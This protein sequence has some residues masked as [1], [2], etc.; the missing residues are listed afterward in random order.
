VGRF[1][2]AL[3]KL[4]EAESMLRRRCRSVTWELDLCHSMAATSLMYM[5]RLRE[6][7][8][9]TRTWTAAAR[10]R[11]D[12]YLEDLLDMTGGYWTPLLAGDVEAARSL[13]QRG[14]SRW[15][16]AEFHSVEILE[17]IAAT[18]IA[19]FGDRPNAHAIFLRTSSRVD[20]QIVKRVPTLRV[21]LRTLGAQS[22]L[23]SARGS[24]ACKTAC[25]RARA[26][27]LRLSR[28]ALGYGP[29]FGALLG[30][31][32]ATQRGDNMRAVSLLNEA[33]AGF[34]VHEMGLYAS[35]SRYQEGVLI[36][37]EQGRA[38]VARAIEWA[39][40]YGGGDPVALLETVSPGF[41][42]S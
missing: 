4:E 22:A 7:G 42:R 31:A 40:E 17:C 6:L 13:L 38:Q 32:V 1:G 37:G 19:L 26:A 3:G 28:E 27:A 39:Q 8:A 36:G 33:A 29:A 11:G 25:A 18:H 23:A 20:A 21:L 10:D 12:R 24:G 5:G 15:R 16:E 14:V 41:A 2:Q 9:C 35:A 30:A 34:Q